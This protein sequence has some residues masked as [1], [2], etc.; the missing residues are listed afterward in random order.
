[1]STAREEGLQA[2]RALRL[3]IPRRALRGHTGN[4]L[5]PRGGESL[6]FHDYRDYTPG[7]DL[8]NLDWNVYARTEREVVK[9]RREEIAPVVEIFRDRSPSMSVPPS[10]DD[11]AEFLL[12]LLTAAAPTCRV[13]ERDEPKTPRA[14]RIVVSDLMTDKDPEAEAVRL[15]RNA[16][17]LIV[18]RILARDESEPP[19]SGAFE[20]IDSETNEAREINLSGPAR[21][22]YLA[23]LAAHT[24]RWRA[25]VR[26]VGGAFADLPSDAPRTDV[27][28]AL[29]EAGIV[30]AK[31]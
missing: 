7:D 19:A 2:G 10:K 12:G 1:M 6:E 3:V 28:S 11:A 13:V 5:G 24:A 4:E 18:V 31:S 17:A 15:S 20:F 14:M 23:A 21:D 16:A 26:R 22:E 29:A 27:V 30:E 25:A 9:I 8:R